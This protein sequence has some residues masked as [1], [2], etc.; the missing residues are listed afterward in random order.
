MS[1]G[2]K[3]VAAFSLLF[4]FVTLLFVAS[5]V[6]E[7]RTN[8]QTVG[9]L[10][11]EWCIHFITKLLQS[12]FWRHQIQLCCYGANDINRWLEGNYHASDTAVCHPVS[13]PHLSAPFV[14]L[15]EFDAA[16][17]SGFTYG[18]EVKQPTDS[19]QVNSH[20]DVVTG[21]RP[22][23]AELGEMSSV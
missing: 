20:A 1:G 16:L 8:L 3:T 13:S 12:Y 2:K 19:G 17:K 15:N 22:E 6:R 10:P 7:N 4:A 18:G 23:P 14:V 11:E 9:I 5:P 21:N